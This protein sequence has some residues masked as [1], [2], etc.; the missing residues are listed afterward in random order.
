MTTASDIITR[1]A[2]ALGYLGRTET[3]SAGDATDGLNTFNALLD[4]WSNEKLMSY[5]TL[6][7]SFPLVVG[8][9]SYTIG[10]GGDINVARPLDI[11]QAFLRDAQNNDYPIVIVNQETWNNIGEKQITSQ[12]P[13]TLF[14]S[15]GYPLGTIYIFPV[16]LIGYTI[17]YDSVTNQVT[18]SDLTTSLSMPPGY[19]RAFIMNLALE[20][21]SAGFPI[22][23]DDKT[24]MRL[25]DNASEAKANVKRTNIKEVL[26]EYD[27]AI[28]SQ[29]QAT[30]N[31]YSDGYNRIR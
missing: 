8:T 3:L 7:R 11:T 28:I 24:Y 17:F 19:E 2:R 1:A 21:V 25:M 13:D 14:Y 16:P 29:S 10:S 15:S 18:F 31:I 26:A 5:V 12:L 6:Q 20:L 27:P 23:L 22:L 4:S 30:Y 9:Q